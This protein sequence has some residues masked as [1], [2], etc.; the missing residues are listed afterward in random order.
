MYKNPRTDLLT[1]IKEI[2]HGMLHLL[3]SD[4]QSDG[5]DSSVLRRD[6]AFAKSL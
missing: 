3:C 5:F 2:L 1:F 6:V 4:T